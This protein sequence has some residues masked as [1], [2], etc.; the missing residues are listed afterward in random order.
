MP[1]ISLAALTLFAQ[2]NNIPDDTSINE[3]CAIVK[4]KTRLKASSHA[5][6]EIVQEGQDATG[7]KFV[8]M[9]THFFSY[10]WNY[11]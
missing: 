11:L 1:G 6:V 10:A 2:E 4:R 3:V 8:G 7:Q 9:A 5:Y